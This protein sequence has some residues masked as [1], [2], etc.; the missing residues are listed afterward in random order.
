MEFSKQEYWSRLPCSPPG[1]L[2]DSGI[3]PETLA[4]PSLAGGFFATE[5][6]VYIIGLWLKSNLLGYCSTVGL[7]IAGTF[8]HHLKALGITC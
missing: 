4:S 8:H 6:F 3:K 1:D 7:A 5:S 2:A